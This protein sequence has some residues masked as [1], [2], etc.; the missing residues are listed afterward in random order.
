MLLS[1]LIPML[2]LL[3]LLLLRL[4]LLLLYTKHMIGFSCRH[5]QQCCNAVVNAAYY[6]AAAAVPFLQPCP[7]M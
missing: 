3:L 4:R 6:A 7:A 2:L 5:A 1:L